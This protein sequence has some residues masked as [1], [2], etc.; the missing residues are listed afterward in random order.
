MPDQ[1]R[2]QLQRTLGSAF[3]LERELGGGGMSRVF[4][5]D[6]TRLNRKVVV[7]VLSPELAAGVSAARFEQEIKLAASLQQANI[8]PLLN[9]GE[10][11]GLPF[12]MMPFVDGLTLRAGLEA[13]GAMPVAEVVSVLRDVA[14]A[15]AYAHERGVVHRDIKPENVLLSGDAAVVADFGIAKALSAA[16]THTPGETLTQ[17]GT[18][19]GTPKYMAPE[20]ASGDP[21]TDHRADLYALGCVA[22]EMLA[23]APPFSGRSVH[24]LF[25]AHMSEAPMQIGA[26]RADTPPALAALV[27]RCLEKDP[28]RR[29]QSAREILQ[30]LDTVTSGAHAPSAPTGTR[31]W[32]GSAVLLAVLVAVVVWMAQRKRSSENTATGT[33]TRFANGMSDEVAGVLSKLPGLRVASHRS[34]DVVRERHLSP[35]D[36]GKALNVDLL[37][38][39]TVRRVGE[40]VR[41][42]ANLTNAA[43][44]SIRWTKSYDRT[45]SDAFALQ[46]DM[47]A[48]IAGEL[49]LALGTNAVAAGRAGRTTNDQAYDLYLRGRHAEQ[50]GTE[51]GFRQAIVYYERALV[52][53]PKF[54]RAQAAIGLVWTYVADAYVPA[55]E[56]YPH[57]L[58]AAR[59]ALALDSLLAEAHAAYGYS[60]AV[61]TF[62]TSAVRYVRRAVELDPNSADIRALYGQL[63]CWFLVNRCTDAVAQVEKAVEL[64]PLSP[65]SRWSLVAT[66][67]FNRR[68]DDA[69]A[70]AHRLRDVDP[71][72]ALMDDGGAASRRE[73]GDFAGAAKEYE[74]AQKYFPQPMFGRAITYARMGR[75]DDARRIARELEGLRAKGQ[76]VIPDFIAMIY[77]S[78]GD[79]DR[80]FQWLETARREHSA[81]L[82]F[83]GA[84]P[85]YDPIRSDPRY[86]EFVRALGAR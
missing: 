65:I 70:A 86:A 69:I 11:D 53:D 19:L 77:A 21:A 8:V 1:L 18:S 5:A 50:T 40:R 20:Q 45:T 85:E 26:K 52:L 54:A 71:H 76:Q 17:A 81:W 30:S 58:V 82:F 74:A 56:A 31:V 25:A 47:A 57:A 13:G 2:D 33:S 9:A 60:T 14:R 28:S 51:A 80:A 83:L 49:Q 72:F 35:Q 66:L 68:Y 24:Q 48:A 73:K 41:V 27:M 78:L 38:D 75:P 84:L 15:L 37:L 61:L 36:I 67:Y 79:K 22:Y 4:V 46:D 29:P 39:G 10:T 55:A 6:E 3:T 43:D 32:I 23:G 42:T 7:K 64:D 62:D 12:Y 34:V 59:R 44:A 63:L 16:R